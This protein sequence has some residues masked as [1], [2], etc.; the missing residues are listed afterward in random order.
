MSAITRDRHD[1][2]R[3]FLHSRGTG[4]IEKS[5][6]LFGF[7]PSERDCVSYLKHLQHSSQYYIKSEVAAFFEN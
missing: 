5:D 1:E 3:R 4:K 6:A 2:Y 7:L